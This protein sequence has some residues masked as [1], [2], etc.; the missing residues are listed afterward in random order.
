ML[1]KFDRILQKV[2]KEVSL[3]DKNGNSFCKIEL[4]YGY[5]LLMLQSVEA[6]ARH[7]I[8]ACLVPLNVHEDSLAYALVKSA[9]DVLGPGYIKTI[10]ADRAFLDGALFTKLMDL[11]IDFITPAKKNNEILS[12]MKGLK[13]IDGA[14]K[15]TG[16]RGEAIYGFLKS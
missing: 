8:A 7:I 16:K 11:G 2:A 15:A 9:Y 6:D 3:T 5:K 12:D 4:K 14:I 13:K 1:V 10:I